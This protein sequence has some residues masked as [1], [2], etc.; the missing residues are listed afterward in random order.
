MEELRKATKLINSGWLMFW[1]KFMPG[2]SEMQF[3]SVFV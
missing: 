3:I 1:P 2:T